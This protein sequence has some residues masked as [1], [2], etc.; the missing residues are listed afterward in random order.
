[1]MRALRLSVIVVAFALP[2][3]AQQPTRAELDSIRAGFIRA[4]VEI[5]RAL[6]LNR[7]SETQLI[8][9]R[10]EIR[11]Y[12]ARLDSLIARMGGEPAPPPVDTVA[13]APPDTVAPPPP[14]DT[15][16]P[17]PPPPPP[18]TDTTARIYAQHDFNDNQWGPFTNLASNRICAGTCIRN[19]HAEIL[20]ERL[21]TSS[22]GDRN[23]GVKWVP[24]D[25]TENT[26]FGAT[27]YVQG[28]FTIPSVTPESRR[29]IDSS[30][31]R[32]ALL[33]QT[34]T[35]QELLQRKLFYFNPGRKNPAVLKIHALALQFVPG[36]G[37]GAPCSVTAS[38]LSVT[39]HRFTDAE[40][41]DKPQVIGIE[42]KR[43]SGIR[44]ADGEAKI[45]LN[46]VMVRH[47]T[48]FCTNEDTN[49]SWQ[50]Q[51]GQQVSYTPRT[52]ELYRELRVLDDVIVGNKRASQ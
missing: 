29:M 6:G 43:S 35:A 3:A 11:M 47:V 45:Y 18:V 37:G 40:L 51:I 32:W 38:P 1:M 44:V 5:G 49:T 25:G 34:D 27:L 23:S 39:V 22:A 19:Q 2:A 20:F 48:G 4:D 9:T 15:T 33:P 41:F 52:G 42:L 14:V 13:P 10:V 31:T 24:K 21:D 36:V 12:I 8:K 16:T 7:G 17:T 28:T 46:G 50:V 26:P 30:A